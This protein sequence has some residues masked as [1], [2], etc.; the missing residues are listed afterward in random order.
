MRLRFPT[1]M[2]SMKGSA[3]ELGLFKMHVTFC[4]QL[5]R[6]FNCQSQLK[7]SQISSKQVGKHEGV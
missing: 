1:K 3:G 5:A 6:W 2:G 4:V 7:G